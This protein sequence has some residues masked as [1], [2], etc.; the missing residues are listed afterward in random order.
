[1]SISILNRGA[2]GGL[3]PELT[4]TASSGSTIDLL[5][6][7]IIVATYTL[8]AD[9]TEHT[10]IV[11]VGTYTVRGTLGT[12]TN[13]AEVVIDAVGQFNVSLTY[14]QVPRNGLIAEYLFENDT[15]SVIYDTSGNGVNLTN[16]G[17]TFVDALGGKGMRTSGT[18]CVNAANL[19]ARLPSTYEI[20]LAV[21]FGA[22]MP[23]TSTVL[24]LYPIGVYKRFVHMSCNR[25]GTLGVTGNLNTKSVVIDPTVTNF[26]FLGANESRS[27]FQ[28]NDG[29]P[30]AWNDSPYRNAS[31]NCGTFGNAYN[32]AVGGAVNYYVFG[33][34]AKI[35]VYNRQLTTEERTA[36][37]N[38]GHGL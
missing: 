6:N 10:F 3:K 31:S 24:D 29:E 18:Q 8:G 1:M 13:E 22:N 23:D 7:G 16:V 15:A 37:Y 14:Y 5:Q 20:S 27:W 12:N 33:F 30:I 25:G 35:R 17:A 32:N 11:K 19:T 36:L 26:M 28:I 21:N 4:V 38:N 2:S 34:I 9:E